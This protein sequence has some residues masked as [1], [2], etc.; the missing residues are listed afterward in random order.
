VKIIIARNF[1]TI[2]TESTINIDPIEL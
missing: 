2:N 1:D